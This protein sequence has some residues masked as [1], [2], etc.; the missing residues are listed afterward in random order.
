MRMEIQVEEARGTGPETTACSDSRGSQD[1]VPKEKHGRRG[2]LV[3]FG[4]Q[5]ILAGACMFS[6]LGLTVTVLYLSGL[7]RRSWS[8]LLPLLIV[9]FLASGFLI[10]TG[11][12]SVTARRWA[13]HLAVAAAGPWF[14]WGVLFVLSGSFLI[15]QILQDAPIEVFPGSPLS[16]MDPLTFVLGTIF[17]VCVILPMSLILFY[18]GR[19]VAATFSHEPSCWTDRVSPP[20]FS[21]ALLLWFTGTIALA[22]AA[23]PAPFPVVSFFIRGTRARILW[24][25]AGAALG[26]CGWLSCTRNK[27]GFPAIVAVSG[28]LMA[29]G[30]GA[31][32]KAAF[33]GNRFVLDTGLGVVAISAI[34][35][36]S[37]FLLFAIP[38]ALFYL[39]YM[40]WI[41]AHFAKKKV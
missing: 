27:W 35:L 18:G 10:V 13:R 15:P 25:A 37:L 26:G 28:G 5:E 29:A 22:C 14:A 20:V 23:E 40:P 8:G 1:L 17:L 36:Q 16:P 39:G 9:P 4:A 32:G 33:S 21:L 34:E 38:A 7:L 31:F 24:A 2:W 30:I 6:L 12:G 11:T 41:W 3:F 19:K